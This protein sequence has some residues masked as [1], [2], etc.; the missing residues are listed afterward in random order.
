VIL[1]LC[2]LTK[3]SFAISRLQSNQS[4][5]VRCAEHPGLLRSPMARR[6]L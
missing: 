5:T 3:K 1:F 6:D 4:W 2:F